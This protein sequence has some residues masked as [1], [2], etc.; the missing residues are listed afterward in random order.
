MSV[1]TVSRALNDKGELAA[2]QRQRVLA[3]ARRLHYVP[4]SAARTLVSGRSRT[5]GVI[6]NDNTSP[7]YAQ[8]L[9]GIEETANARGFGLVF[10]NSANSQEQALRCLD[11]L[12]GNHVDGVLLTPVQTD[13]RDLKRL[14]RAGVPFVLLLRHFDDLGTDFVA[15][16]N[17]T[18]GRI[19]TRHLVETGYR[20]VAFVGGPEH[21]STSR[22][23]GQGYREALEAAGLGWDPE[24]EVHAEFS[25]EGG[26]AAARRLLAL[27]PRPDAIFASTDL[28]AVGVLKAA[29][30]LGVGVPDQ[31]ALV[32]GDDIELSEFLEPPLTTFSQRGREIG[33]LG[34]QILL[35]RLDGDRQPVRQVRLEPRLVI[36]RS[37]GC[38]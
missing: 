36:R 8:V 5:L 16:D 29:R 9:A 21:T 6:V 38:R 12:I 31:L 20:R 35:D 3:I 17:V 34:T 4:S 26:R 7:V 23:R 11:N 25:V 15:A 37:C 22:L 24:L 30:E 1:T 14:Q 13:D 2:H 18:A 28:Q 27:K 32:G 10:A 19:A 33:A